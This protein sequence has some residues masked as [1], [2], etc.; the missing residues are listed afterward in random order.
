VSE[1]TN[2]T[3][4][5][6]RRRRVLLGIGSAL[7]VLALLIAG[8]AW[9]LL[10][11]EPGAR[12]LFSRLGGAMAGSLEVADL[13]G[14]IR[15]P[16][17][18]GGLVYESEGFEVRV[19]RLRLEW[20]LRELLA[21]RLDV[22]SL[23]AEGVTVTLAGEEERDGEPAPLPDVHL[24]VNIIVRSAEV[25]GIRIV[26]PGAEPI[27]IDSLDLAT[28]AIGDV[29]EIERLTIRSPEIAA[30]VAGRVEPQGDYPV[31]L[32]L[33]WS[34]ELPGQPRWAGEGTFTGTLEELRVEHALGAPIAARV[35]A[36]LTTPLRDLSFEGRVEARPFALA[37]LGGE[38]PDGVTI[39]GRVSGSGTLE[40]LEAEADLSAD[41]PDTGPTRV[42]ALLTRDGERWL[43][44]RLLVTSPA[45]PTRIEAESELRLPEG[46]PPR[47]D[48]RASWTDL[49]FPLTGEPA[50][51]SPEG[52]AQ[53]AG[54]LAAWDLV[55]DLVV[56]Q[57]LAAAGL[58]PTPLELNGR[59]GE[60]GLTIERAEARLLEGSLTARGTLAWS[61]RVEW[62]LAVEGRGL[63]PSALWPD[64]R[65]SE[66]SGRLALTARTAGHLAEAGPVGRIAP[67]RLAGTL[68]GEP[69]EARGAVRLD[70]ERVTVS[71]LDLDWGTIRLA[72]DG[73]V[74][75][76]FDFKFDL[77]APNLGLALLGAAGSLTAGGRV[78]GPFET[79]RIAATAAGEGLSWGDY[80]AAELTVEAD[81][82]FAPG[83]TLDLDAEATRAAAAERA[84]ERIAV[85]LAGTRGE[86]RL[87]LTAD[88]EQGGLRL[89][90]AGGLDGGAAGGLS[91]DGIWRGTLE[92][93]DL[94]L[95][96]A[97]SWSLAAPAPVTASAEQI[98]VGR[99]CEVSGAARLC[100]E[101]AWRGEQGWQASAELTEVPL[102]LAGTFLPPDVEISG[103]IGG[104]AAASAGAGGAITATADL[105]PGPGEVVYP[106]PGGGTDVL[107]FGRGALT[108]SAGEGG[109]EAAL[110]LPL[111]DLG[112]AA[113]T[114]ELPGYRL[115]GAP[116]DDQPIAGTLTA[117][118]TDLGFLQAFSD[119][120][121]DTAGRLD[122]DLRIAGTVGRPRIG[123]R[124]LLEDGRAAVPGLGIR[125]TEMRL[126]ATGEEMDGSE[127]GP[128]RIEGSVRSGDGT[129]TLAGTAP[130][131]PGPE[132]PIRLE[133]DGRRF[134]AMDTPEVHLLANPDLAI[135]YDGTRLAVEGEVVVPEA[136][137]E[138]GKPPQSAVV[139]SQDVVYVG[140]EDPRE[141]PEPALPIAMRVRVVLGDDVE[142]DVL[143]LAAEP[144]GSILLV[145]EP[146]RP[147]RGTGEIDLAGGTYQ[148]YGQD[149]TIE[150]GR[151]IFAGPV[152]NPR[153]DLR[154]SRT[155]DDG[156]VAGL[157][158]KGTLEQPEITL[159]SDPPM[160]QSNQLSYLLLGR[161]L[162]QA[163]PEEGNLMA[164]AATSLGIK[165]GN[166]LAERLAARFGLE[167]ARIETEGGYEE[168]S[169]VLGKYLS[170][171]LYVAYGVG[172]FEAANTLRIRYLLSSRWT[173]EATTGEATAADLL[174]TIERGRG[175]KRQVPED[176]EEDVLEPRAE[177]AAGGI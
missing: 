60:N 131:V 43:F 155:A 100:A 107:R 38:L 9:F 29:V 176:D 147:T 64:G 62:D 44:E 45:A 90:A 129:L 6:R 123:G 82:D 2:R 75:P 95:P 11:T 130:P 146:G 5:R 15:G 53:V 142:I 81:F 10:A 12:W 140:G 33:E 88:A 150:R 77:E 16:L 132:R 34:A 26:Q 108:A 101:G 168:A 14:P 166:L 72:A 49:V 152:D 97:G 31:D 113:A 84:F 154:A 149:L 68:R 30:E 134:L 70:G 50:L 173:L 55:A 161:P 175:A 56:A 167:E 159:W 87:T 116:G 74:M 105:R 19:E 102:A 17:T 145:D 80:S 71:D 177:P 39:G 174:Y 28:R 61:P 65:S 37:R 58:P 36:V 92:T 48:L 137:I 143:G 8:A 171:R 78:T 46:E 40:A 73:R 20:H 7:A 170:P 111:P 118:I 69:V 27:V 139:I 85:D 119:Q 117:E 21:R 115:A 148:A 3:R 59:G 110:D 42:Q 91:A 157:E 144:E 99:L 151:L 153:I 54:N 89:A 22:V 138:I 135:T 133:I 35:E 52:R 24:P 163:S 114:L 128:L 4:P 93:L 164:N 160:D 109:V 98:E 25:R 1:S 112:S 158:A 122:A 106:L 86:H 103:T 96:D 13:E 83:G 126:L 63:D 136:E 66:N 141:P 57:P 172:L 169:L 23:E 67:L 41:T 104:T 76:S 124:A 94:E 156:V 162:G 51:T 125:L 32:R 127:P 120:L 18:V 79:P 47:F 165:G 121:D